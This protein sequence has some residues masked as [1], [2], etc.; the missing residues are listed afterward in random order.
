MKK[1]IIIIVAVI[2]L[3][4][5]AG[6]KVYNSEEVVDVKEDNSYGV[7]LSL[8][9]SSLEKLEG[10][11]T[12]VI[13]AEYYTKEQI[14]SLHNNGQVV[15]SYLNVGSIESF[16]D[17]Y[18]DF[19]NLALGKY[20]NWDEEEWVNV[21]DKS[22]QKHIEDLS[23]EYI[24]KGI[25]GFFID[26]CD[27]YYFNQKEEIY[28]G[29]KDILVNLMKNDLAV[30]INGGDYFVQK[31]YEENNTVKDA[32]TGINQE[33]IFSAIDFDNNKLKKAKESDKEYYLEYVEKYSDLGLDIYL[34][35]YTT[36]TKIKDEVIEFC[37]E[38]GW[39]YYFSDS[40]ELD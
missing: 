4:V 24:K 11:D 9:G 40:I 35:E 3:A 5:F 15:Y 19:S 29:V 22:W 21:S 10:Y 1:I 14:D 36:D 8:D 30:I 39:K 18:S 13:D 31:Y 34:L 25:D 17:Y 33:T 20:E 23:Q 37:N 32:M 28:N 7:F 26:N 27:V 12:V 16:R 6:T 2:S 38:K